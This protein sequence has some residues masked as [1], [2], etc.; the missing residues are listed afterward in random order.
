MKWNADCVGAYNILRL[1]LKKK[2]KN[3]E[4]NPMEVKN[5]QIIKVAV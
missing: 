2:N 3:I 5:P 1:Y 4:L